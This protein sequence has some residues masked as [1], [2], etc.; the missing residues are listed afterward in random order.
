M[1][2]MPQLQEAGEDAFLRRIALH[3]SRR[4]SS[5]AVACDGVS[6]TWRGFYEESLRI[7][8]TLRLAGYQLGER[9]AF[10]AGNSARYAVAFVGA[11]ASGFSAVTLPTSL[12]PQSLG[13]MLD[14]SNPRVLFASAE[15]RELAEGALDARSSHASIELVGFDFAADRWRDY[16]RWLTS[17]SGAV[18]EDVP[19]DTEF[20]VVYSSGTTG[21]PKGIAHTHLSRVAFS[22]GFAGLSFDETASSV[23]ATPLYSNMSIPP[24]LTLVWCGGRAVILDKFDP[25]SFIRA[26]D[27][28]AATHFV[29]VPTMAQRVLE[30]GA[31]SPDAFRATRIKYVGGSAVTPQLKADLMTRWPGRLVVAYGQTEGG[32]YT[33]QHEFD[34]DS[35]LGSVGR[36]VK[37]CDVRI[38]DD[39]GNEL[40]ANAVG[41]IVGRMAYMM[42]GYIN[43]PEETEKLT[44]RD[45]EGR[46]F[47]KTGDVG[48]LDH[49]GY[50]YILDRKKDV[51]IS[52]GFNI[53][54]IDLEEVVRSHPAVFDAAVIGVRSRRWGETPI[55]TVKLRTGATA[56][57]EA[58]L[59]WSNERLG[60]IQRL[61]RVEIVEDLPHNANGKILKAELRRRYADH[62]LK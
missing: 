46:R 2:E 15:Y 26:A 40:G 58:I 9:V 12:T 38:V 61:S 22:K 56:T 37:G 60:K 36:P 47:F 6:I 16:P 42:S 54:A 25:V 28:F 24:L 50:L 59:E 44:W 52:G 48:R 13:A 51:I 30:S 20:N 7:G 27:T 1:I 29:M 31:F 41:E 14:D 57:A 32:P 62:E 5:I 4:P 3:A 53:Y 33:L 19:G 35:K 55:A 34:D 21:I 8:A 23:I 45:R 18:V 10:L 39:A 49:D 11:A 17:A 43:K